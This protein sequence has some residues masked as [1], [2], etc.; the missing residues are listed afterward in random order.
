MSA[1][2]RPIATGE[3]EQYQRKT[4]ASRQF[5]AEA[6][7]YMPGGDSRSTLFYRPY[8]AVMERGEGCWLSDLD[9][10]RLLDFTGNHSVLIHGYAHP[11]IRA[12]IERQLQKGTC[13]PGSSEPQ[14]EYARLLCQRIPS[15]ERVR[16]TNSGTEAAL[17]AIRAARGFT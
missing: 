11:H 13:F 14:L 1:Q 8:P 5:F 4:A 12:A 15:I 10:N 9:G 17:N 2:A 7:Q 6:R 3:Q 16:F